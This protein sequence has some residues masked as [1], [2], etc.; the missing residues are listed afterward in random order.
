MADV[1]LMALVASLDAGLLAAAVVLLGRPRPAHKLLAYLVGGMGFSIGFGLII[2]LALHGSKLLRDPSPSTSAVIE[3]VAGALL[4]AVAIAVRVGRVPQWRPRRSPRRE[5]A[6]SGRRPS[7]S[8]RAVGRDSLWIAWAAG[9]LYSVPGAY[10]LAGM[11]LLAKQD[12]SVVADVIVVVAFNVIMFALIELP[13][14]GFRVAPERTR[15][16]TEG[17]N[18]W[19]T[20]HKRTLIVV[21]AG[22]GGAY[23]LVSGLID[24]P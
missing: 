1:F 16:L 23:L 4:V 3:I 2:V 13:L 11:A 19:M 14:L 7:L 5:R 22:A 6:D 20:R 8:E 18:D 12:T 9:A 24:L 10:Y 21:V 17:L 15:V